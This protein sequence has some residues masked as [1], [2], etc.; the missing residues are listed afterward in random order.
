MKHFV[1]ETDSIPWA[2]VWAGAAAKN[3]KEF[4]LELRSSNPVIQFINGG[5]LSGGGGSIPLKLPVQDEEFGLYDFFQAE[6]QMREMEEI[7]GLVMDHK[8][9]VVPLQYSMLVPNILMHDHQTFSNSGYYC[10]EPGKKQVRAYAGYTVLLESMEFQKQA[11]A[12]CEGFGMEWDSDQV[13]DLSSLSTLE[14]VYALGAL[15]TANPSLVILRASN[16]LS[17]VLRAWYSDIYCLRE[18]PCIINLLPETAAEVDQRKVLFW[19]QQIPA[20][21]SDEL[22]VFKSRGKAWKIRWDCGFDNHTFYRRAA[23]GIYK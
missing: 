8:I 5:L 20:M 15:S 19:P 23:E 18:R 17:Y 9:E 4:S 2:V 1:L 11:E 14:Q 3:P 22:E 10:P 13:L 16:D 6:R 12:Y 21:M 7:H